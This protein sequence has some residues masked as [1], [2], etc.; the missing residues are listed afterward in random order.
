MATSL[1]QRIAAL[2]RS[3]AA[4]DDIAIVHISR[5]DDQ[6]RT[7]EEEAHRIITG[8]GQ[9]W[10]RQPGETEDAFIARAKREASAAG[11]GVLV[12][13]NWPDR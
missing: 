8:A 6:C 11:I 7:I 13:S 4:A 5:F 2:E 3:R 1:E 10:D 9:S 12:I